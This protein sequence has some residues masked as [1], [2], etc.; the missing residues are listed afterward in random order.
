MLL[1]QDD[2]PVEEDPVLGRTVLAGAEDLQAVLVLRT[3][4]GGAESGRHTQPGNEIVYI[5]EG[6]VIL[7]IDGSE[8]VTVAAGETFQTSAG[9]V[10]NVKNT[11]ADDAVRA[12]AFYIAGKDAEVK[13]LSVPAE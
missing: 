6:S 2:D 1:A 13:D 11:S 5:L 12:L 9:E 10:H 7:E 3:L 8:P 4:P